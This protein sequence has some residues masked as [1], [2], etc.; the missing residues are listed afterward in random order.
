[1][2]KIINNNSNNKN[3]DNKNNGWVLRLRAPQQVRS[4]AAGEVPGKPKYSMGTHCAA[5][6]VGW[7]CWT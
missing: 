7:I 2:K 3:I 4:I 6:P 5:M 1:M